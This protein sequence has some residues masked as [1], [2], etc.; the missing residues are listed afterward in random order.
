MER[1]L[2]LLHIKSGRVLKKIGKHCSR[3]N[4]FHNLRIQ[5]I[6]AKPSR[7]FFFHL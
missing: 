1:D 4:E 7:F 3:R 6:Y 5:Q 2:K